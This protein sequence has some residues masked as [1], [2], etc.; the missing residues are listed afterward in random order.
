MKRQ[1]MREIERQTELQAGGPTDTR[2]ERRSAAANL[3]TATLRTNSWASVL[4]AGVALLTLAGAASAQ[5]YKWVDEK[6]V[7]HFGDTPPPA[8]KGKP[9]ALQRRGAGESGGAQLP[10]ALA[11]AARNSPVTLYT[12]TGCES[13]E[14]GRQLLRQ[15]GVPFVE[16]TVSSNE[17]LARLKEISNDATLPVLVVGQRKLVG[18]EASDWGNALTF[19]AYPTSS[20]LPQGYQT[21]RAEQAAPTKAAVPERPLARK[22]APVDTP[23]PAANAEGEGDKPPGFQF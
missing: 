16:K 21:G 3:S 1:I 17:D 12:M 23:R 4:A 14:R 18:F 15:R 6:G 9:L 8:D 10:Y 5:M 11:E 2:S 22:Q 13:C 7:T 20:A 19:A